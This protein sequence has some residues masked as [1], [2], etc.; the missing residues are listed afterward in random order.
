MTLKM[1]RV[2]ISLVAIRARKLPISI[3]GRNSRTLPS[4]ID[5]VG[6]WRRTTGNTGKNAASALRTNDLV[7]RQ[8]L[9]SVR[10]QSAIY[11]S[12]MVRIHPG[13]RRLAIG[14]AKGTRRKA[15]I[16]VRTTITRRSRGNGLRISLSSGRGRR[17]DGLMRRSSVR[18]GRLLRRALRMRNVGGRRK[19]TDAGVRDDRRV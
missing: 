8:V 10:R 19:S 7:A 13:R 11:T 9:C 18:L 4:G 2:Q 1:F 12:H 6:D 3:L 16:V 17:Q 15:I 14:I 5:G